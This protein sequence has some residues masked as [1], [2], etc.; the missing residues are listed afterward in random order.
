MIVAAGSPPVGASSLSLW[1]W[2][3]VAVGTLIG[4]AYGA[5]RYARQSGAAAERLEGRLSAIERAMKPNG[6]D[7][8]QIG[9]MMKRTE[10]MV[11]KLSGKLDQHIGA[12]AESRKEIWRAIDRK[13]DRVA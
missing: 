13:Q 6:L 2:V 9:D 11:E 12:E 1:L 4:F 3:A 7:T 8:D 5:Y 10:A